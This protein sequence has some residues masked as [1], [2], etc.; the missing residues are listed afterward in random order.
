MAMFNSYVKLPEGI[1]NHLWHYTW[2]N[3]GQRFT[4]ILWDLEM[5]CHVLTWSE[6]EQWH[7]IYYICILYLYIL[8]IYIYYVYT[9][10]HIKTIEYSCLLPTQWSIPGTNNFR[11]ICVT[12]QKSG[13]L[14]KQV[15]PCF[16]YPLWFES[17]KQQPILECLACLRVDDTIFV[18]SIPTFRA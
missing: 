14:K 2:T 5:P 3:Q 4:A 17:D 15:V 7:I 1:L 8:H 13:Y 11:R 18:G 6:A 9:Y 10:V 12:F 16:P